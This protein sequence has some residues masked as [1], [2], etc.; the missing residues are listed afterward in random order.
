MSH[1]SH[2]SE[3]KDYIHCPVVALTNQDQSLLTDHNLCAIRGTRMFCTLCN[4]Q[5]IQNESGGFPAT[6]ERPHG[7]K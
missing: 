5:V 3:V 7:K 4:S 6:P 1:V 2:F